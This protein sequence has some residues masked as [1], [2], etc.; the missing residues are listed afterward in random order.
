LSVDFIFYTDEKVFSVASENHGVYAPRCQETPDI[1]WN[2]RSNLL[3]CRWPCRASSVLWWTG[4]KS[5]V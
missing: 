1:C 2:C 4:S 5:M 3:Q